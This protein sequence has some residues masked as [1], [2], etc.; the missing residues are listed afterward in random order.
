MERDLRLIRKKRALREGVK[1]TPKA[2]TPI[3]EPIKT[4]QDT[5]AVV[6]TEVEKGTEN[7]QQLPELDDL[8]MVDIMDMGSQPQVALLA[9]P[10]QAPAL[11]S[12]EDAAMT[13]NGMPQDLAPQKTAGLAITVEPTSKQDNVSAAKEIDGVSQ[14]RTTI[15]VVDASGSAPL[16]M[17]EQQTGTTD[18]DFDSMFNDTDFNADNGTMNFDMDFSATETGNQDLP[19]DNTFGNMAMTSADLENVVTTTNEDINS[20]LPGLDAYVNATV[21]TTKSATSALPNA[22]ETTG[23]APAGTPQALSQTEPKLVPIESSFEDMFSS[24]TFDLGDTG[25]DAVMGD[26]ELGDFNF[27]EEWLKM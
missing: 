21:D 20:L 10:A 2:A 15:P 1:I 3:E 23:Q 26:G 18:F 25:G 24:D 27:D 17:S 7:P 5:E 14:E 16:D 8:A 9:N 11:V 4:S 6:G 22:S 12:H 13:A 19:S